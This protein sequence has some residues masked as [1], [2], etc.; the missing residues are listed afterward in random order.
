MAIIFLHLKWIYIISM[1][2]MVLLIIISIK[3]CT[4]YASFCELNK[5][6]LIMRRA[7]IITQ[8][9][10]QT[11]LLMRTFIAS[12]VSLGHQ[13]CLAVRARQFR[14]SGDYHTHM[15]SD[16]ARMRRCTIKDELDK[17]HLN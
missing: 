13:V 9:L 14:A 7:Y 16:E 12:F 6:G 11:K 3:L 10:D 4:L 8:N 17:I 5:I 15:K 1:I 2:L